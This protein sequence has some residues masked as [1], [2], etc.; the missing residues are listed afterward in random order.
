MKLKELKP[1]LG[2]LEVNLFLEFQTPISFECFGDGDYRSVGDCISQEDTM[3][4]KYGEI[5]I[6]QIY[7]ENSRAINIDL[8]NK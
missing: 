2:A 7:S 1:V 4:R 6:E 5:E 3:Y 8:V